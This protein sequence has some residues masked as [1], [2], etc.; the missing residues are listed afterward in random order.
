MSHSQ[1]RHADEADRVE[2]GSLTPPP[3]HD[4]KP[5]QAELGENV[6]ALQASGRETR[7]DA[8]R[9][10]PPVVVTSD[11]LRRPGDRRRAFPPR[12]PHFLKESTSVTSP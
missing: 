10:K 6:T 1:R 12:V 7:R 2:A 5:Q 4:T 8:G 9:Q 3:L 11:R